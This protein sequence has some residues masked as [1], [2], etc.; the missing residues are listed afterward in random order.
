MPKIMLNDTEY[1]GVPLE[2]VTAW[3]PTSDPVQVALPTMGDSDISG[4]G[5]GTVTGAIS[6]LNSELMYE[7]TTTT[8]SSGHTYKCIKYANGYADIWGRVSLNSWSSSQGPYNGLYRISCTIGYPLLTSIEF[9]TANGTNS[10]AFIASAQ[11]ESDNSN[12]ITYFCQA[13]ASLASSMD[14]KTHVFIRGR[15]K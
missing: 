7:Q 9:A 3:P 4:V 13:A 14:I 8:D 2:C 15:W 10:C 5:D 1:S 11:L 6:G 12:R